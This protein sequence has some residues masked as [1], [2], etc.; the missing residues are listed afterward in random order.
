MN[1]HISKYIYTCKCVCTCFER[2]DVVL[3]DIY[4][5]LYNR[6]IQIDGESFERSNVVLCVFR[7]SVYLYYTYMCA[8]MISILRW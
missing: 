4:M 7:I 1:V 5:F 8:Y 6:Y 2:C 3:C